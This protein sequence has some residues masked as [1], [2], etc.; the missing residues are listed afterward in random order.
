M[1]LFRTSKQRRQKV[2]EE[3]KIKKAQEEEEEEEI[4]PLPRTLTPK[5]I[6]GMA[7][8]ND[9]SLRILSGKP[10]D[11]SSPP[12][13]TLTRKFRI[14]EAQTLARA[15]RFNTSVREFDCTGMFDPG[16]CVSAVVEELAKS[17]ESNRA[18]RS[19]VLDRYFLGD[20]GAA[21]VARAL[22]VNGTLRELS[23]RGCGLGN[24][25]A[26]E[27]A[28]ALGGNRGL[29]RLDLT[30][31]FVRDAGIEALGRALEANETVETCLVKGRGHNMVEGVVRGT[32]ETRSDASSALPK[33]PRR[34]PR[35]KQ[36]SNLSKFL[37]IGKGSPGSPVIKKA[38]RS[39]SEGTAATLSSSSE[40]LA[41]SW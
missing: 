11:D 19:L 38:H 22:S 5:L 36:T 14:D 40:D 26:E 20:G 16:Q 2:E 25:G 31:N 27:I 34:R 39:D 10:P 35:K 15:L 7:E 1:P 24:G 6:I 3:E 23:L 29:R 17:L 32:K 21:L 30:G 12:P 33:E 4:M 8:R 18:L 9:P 13:L 28:S 37:D 41:M